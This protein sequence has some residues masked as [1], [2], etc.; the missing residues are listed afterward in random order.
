MSAAIDQPRPVRAEDA[1]DLAR[2]DAFL[3]QHIEGLSGTPELGQFPGGESLPVEVG[4]VVADWNASHVGLLYLG[5]FSRLGLLS[6]YFR[7]RPSAVDTTTVSPCIV[8][9]WWY[10]VAHR[11]T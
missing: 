3:K 8:Q 9:A 11:L 1:F 2:V 4:A 7:I 10:R 6:R 5:R